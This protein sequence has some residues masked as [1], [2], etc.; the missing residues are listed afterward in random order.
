MSAP[1]TRILSDLHYADPGSWLEDLRS[2]EPLL[3]RV[4]RLVLNG[5][6]LDTQVH[7]RAPELLAE[8]RT[9]FPSQA[10]EIE[11]I[12]GNHD[13]DISPLNEVAFAENRVWITHGHVLYDDVAPWSRLVPEIRR[14][15]RLHAGTLSSDELRKLEVRFR[16]FRQICLKLPSEQSQQGRG[17][18]ARLRRIARVVFPPDRLLI[19]LRI[20]R[21]LPELALTFARAQRPDAQV[22]ITGHTHRHGVWHRPDGRIVINTGSFCPPTGGLLVDL[23]ENRITVRQVKRQKGQFYPGPTL[24]EFTLA[25]LPL[26]T[27]SAVS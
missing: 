7:P 1:I 11:F 16:L 26:S 4:D 25:P 12:A 24:T 27:V 17:N 5:D 6:T 2:L 22:I 23:T 19:M 18:W 13:P 21:E 20:W 8:V 3:S 9:F 14:R 10:P 15:F